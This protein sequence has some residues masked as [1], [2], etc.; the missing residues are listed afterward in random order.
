MS[1]THFN[2]VTAEGMGLAF[3]SVIGHE[4]IHRA[5]CLLHAA[6]EKLRGTIGLFVGHDEI[7]GAALLAVRMALSWPRPT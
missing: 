3:D 1:G 6:L 2:C 4:K 7:V 5:T